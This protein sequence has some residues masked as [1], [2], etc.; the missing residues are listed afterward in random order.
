MHIAV[1]RDEDCAVGVDDSSIP[2]HSGSAFPQQRAS[3]FHYKLGDRQCEPRLL[4]HSTSSS[5]TGTEN[6]MLEESAV[7]DRSC[8][9][10]NKAYIL[11]FP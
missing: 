1:F 10:A 5:S 11:S 2:P 7:R 8:P 9:L 3:L 6:G 4:H